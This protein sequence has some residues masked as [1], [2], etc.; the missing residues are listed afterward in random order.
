M[1][2]GFVS[3]L[4]GVA[5]GVAYAVV[6]VR[7]PAPPLIAL[8]GLLGMVV[9]EQMTIAAWRYVAPPAHSSTQQL[10]ASAG[11]LVEPNFDQRP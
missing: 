6:G 2:G 5:V 11:R 1:F 3:L 4:M 7:S 8:I 10:P 9:G